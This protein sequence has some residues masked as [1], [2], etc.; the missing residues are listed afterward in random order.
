MGVGIIVVVCVIVGDQCLGCQIIVVGFFDLD[1]VVG[2]G[3]FVEVGYLVCFV[4]IVSGFGGIGCCVGIDG[5]WCGVYGL[6]GF[7]LLGLYL[8]FVVSIVEL[9]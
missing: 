3:E 4:L 1:Y 9:C 5:V 6:S 7:V 8:G 2:G